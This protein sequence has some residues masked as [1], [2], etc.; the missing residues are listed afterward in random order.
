MA[1][2]ALNQ[3]ALDFSGNLK[4]ILQSCREGKQK[5]A[6]IRTGPELEITGYGCSDHFLELGNKQIVSQ[7]D[8]PCL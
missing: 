2:C 7:Q 5:G 3:T 6:K 8:L 4:R 1:S